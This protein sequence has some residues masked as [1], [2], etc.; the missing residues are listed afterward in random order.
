MFDL[1]RL[2]LL[3]ELAHRGTMTA[4]AEAQGLTSSAVS[5]QLAVLEREARTPL[6]ERI[7]RR[8]RL[9]PEGERLAAHA[10][11][12]L[13][14][15][16]AAALDLSVSRG[17]PAGVLQVAAFATFARARLLPAMV[18]ARARHPALDI[19]LHELEPRESIEAVREG[20]C[21]LAISFAYSL[22]PRPATPG[23][24]SRFLM[25]EP[26]LLA[27]PPHW[28]AAPD[29]LDL[30]RLA[31]EAWIVGSRQADDRRLAETACAAAGFAPRMTHGIGD[32]ELQLEMIAAGLGVGF[33]PALGL[34]FPSAE[35]VVVRAAAGVPI[36]RRI[37]AVTRHAVE[38][39]PR[40]EALLA[41]LA[42]SA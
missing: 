22:A 37:E 40:V 34:R 7:G 28:S 33:V 30:R 38:H 31:D 25:E 9:T 36:T 4:V 17:A 1:V 16:E 8:V 19:V 23:L 5:Q 26:V 11:T 32:Y 10:E 15:V 42:A 35:R 39:S 27:L 2:R 3:R 20:R 13:Q 12:I 6:L 24:T 21:D 14:A 29:P 41:E 18:R